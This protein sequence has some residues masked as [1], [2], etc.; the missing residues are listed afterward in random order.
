MKSEPIA[1][2][3]ES[4]L[5]A[6]DFLIKHKASVFR[7]LNRPLKHREPFLIADQEWE[8]GSI[9][10]SC[11]VENEGGLAVLQGEEL[12]LIGRGPVFGDDGESG[13][14]RG[15]RSLSQGFV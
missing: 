4:Q 3:G 1:I 8:G 6:D 9:L 10:Y 12:E 5:F 2:S 15:R 13:T 14:E 11:V 7:R